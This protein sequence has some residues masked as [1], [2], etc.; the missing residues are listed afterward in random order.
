M[1]FTEITLKDKQLF[2]RYLRLHNPQVSELSFT[3]LFAWRNYYRFKYAEINGLLCIIAKPYGSE[4]YALMPIGSLYIDAFEKTFGELKHHFREMGWKP[5]F[6]KISHAELAYFKNHVN[7]DE[8]MVFDR[9]NSDYL[10]STHDLI[11]LKGKKY[12]GKRNHINKLKSKYDFD[13]LPLDD[14]LISECNRIMEEWCRAK[15]CSCKEGDYCERQANMELLSNFRTLGCKGA[16]I[17]INGKC[18]A[19]TVGEM[20]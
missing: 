6:K 11:F 12:D 13:Y 2:D 14:S 8:D 19:F 16:V 3:N 9:N 20:L 4:P 15:N 7:S 10:Y 17:L 5:V 1:D 18:E